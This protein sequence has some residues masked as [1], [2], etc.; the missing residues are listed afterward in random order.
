MPDAVKYAE[1]FEWERIVRRIVLPLPVK[2]LALVLATYA[3]PDGS[4]VRP[5]VPVL[6]DVTGQSQRTI[7]RQLSSLRRMQLIEMT[8]RGGGR[9]AK[10]KASEYQLTI[11]AD[12]LDTRTLLSPGER[13]DSHATWMAPQS[14]PDSRT[15][16]VDNSDS[17][18][19]WMTPQCEPVTAIETP[20]GG[21]SESIETPNDHFETPPGWHST[22][23]IHQPPRA[24][25]RETTHLDGYYPTEVPTAYA[26]AS[27]RDPPTHTNFS[28]SRR[29]K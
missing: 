1:R 25:A 11:P 8:R 12:L 16:P 13:L 28:H 9:G 29:R 2:C 17:H 26:R 10:G 14:R 27:A 3:D 19:T 22:N 23:H 15:H 5:G 4:R 18:A 21:A 7:N 6:A 24:C 20:H